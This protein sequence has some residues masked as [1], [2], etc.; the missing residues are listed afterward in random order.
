[1]II[2]GEAQESPIESEILPSQ[3]ASNTIILLRFNTVNT[4]VGNV[5]N[6]D[7]FWDDSTTALNQQGVLGADGSY[8]YNI[9]VP[10]EP[11]F[12]NVGNHTIRVDSSVFN[13]GPI[14]FNFTFTITEFVPSQEYLVLNATYHSLLANYTNLFDN[15][16][17]LFNSFNQ[18]SIAYSDLLSTTSQLNL[19][20]NTLLSQ[21]NSMIANYNSLIADYN[22]LEP[23]YRSLALN[24]TSLQNSF[25]SLSSN[26]S[27]LTE[28]YNSLNSSYTSLLS[29]YD[30]ARG[31]L[32]F[33]TNL[34]YIFIA[35]TIALAIIVIYLTMLKPKTPSR[36]R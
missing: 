33:S 28:S 15:Y 31:Q 36:T 5:Q 9:T 7:I 34:N 13:Y 35:S 4:S 25:T 17:Q 11:P 24:Y 10:T 18:T 26:Y 20:Y 16:T 1:M 30:A 14:S 2:H 8:N 6:A 3:G 32:A 21:Y 23:S 19:S 29:S 12:S 22:S 27:N